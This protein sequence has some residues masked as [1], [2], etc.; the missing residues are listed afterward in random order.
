[1]TKLFLSAFVLSTFFAQRGMSQQYTCSAGTWH[2]AIEQN[3]MLT[4]CGTFTNIPVA[5][6]TSCPAA[7]TAALSLF[8]SAPMTDCFRPGCKTCIEKAN[9]GVTVSNVSTITLIAG[10]PTCVV[11]PYVVN[12]NNF[13]NYQVDIPYTCKYTVES[14]CPPKT[15]A[16]TV[17]GVVFCCTSNDDGAV[18]SNTSQFCCT[19][20]ACPAGTIETVV[21]GVTFCC[22]VESGAS[23][24]GDTLKF[25]CSK[26]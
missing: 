6:A 2:V 17:N 1:M 4:N 7:I 11:H 12:N 13:V 25:C 10:T 18:G 20:S 22:A 5:A 16:T 15:I 21:N 19:R 9:P 23:I 8:N 24:N 26:K 3:P 14:A